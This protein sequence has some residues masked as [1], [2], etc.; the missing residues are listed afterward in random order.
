IRRT[1]QAQGLRLSARSSSSASRPASR[2]GRKARTAAV[3]A[4]LPVLEA[5]ILAD[6]AQGMGVVRQLGRAASATPSFSGRKFDC[7]EP[8]SR[9]IP[10][11]FHAVQLAESTKTGTF[12]GPVK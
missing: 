9:L 5:A 1:E 3:R 6:L 12:R 2:Q 8:T 11:G 7:G 4:S 10:Q